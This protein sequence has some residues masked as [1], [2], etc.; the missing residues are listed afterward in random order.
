MQQ[1][2]KKKKS[3]LSANPSKGKALLREGC[4]MLFG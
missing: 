4:S 2:Q 3:L 1:T